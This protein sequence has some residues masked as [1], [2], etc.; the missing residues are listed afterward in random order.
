VVKYLQ[1]YEFDLAIKLIDGFID[2]WKYAKNSK[3]C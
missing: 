3:G 1:E 2:N